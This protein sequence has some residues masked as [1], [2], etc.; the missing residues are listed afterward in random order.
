MKKTI[1]WKTA[2]DDSTCPMC[3]S[4]DIVHE[5]SGCL[6]HCKP[7]C[8]SHPV[9]QTCGYTAGSGGGNSDGGIWVEFGY[10]SKDGLY[11]IEWD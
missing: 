4:T 6:C 10:K 3:G 11:E 7:S 9:C 1:D 8:W 5:D 2:C